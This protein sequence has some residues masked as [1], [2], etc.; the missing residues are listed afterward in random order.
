MIN[1]KKE[2]KYRMKRIIVTSMYKKA[3]G[4][5]RWRPFADV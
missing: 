3:K 2:R 4:R 5:H 1:I